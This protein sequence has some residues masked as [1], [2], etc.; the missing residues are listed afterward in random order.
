MRKCNQCKEIKNLEE[1]HKCKSCKEGRRFICKSCV[2]VNYKEKYA[3]TI[4]AINLT[5]RICS[6]CN[7]EKPKDQYHKRGIGF[8]KICKEC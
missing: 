8:T 4:L 7:I 6:I 3:N 2:A 1:Y 5:H